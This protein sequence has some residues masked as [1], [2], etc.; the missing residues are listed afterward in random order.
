ML[1]Q[2]AANYRGYLLEDRK[3]AGE[4]RYCMRVEANWRQVE[5]LQKQVFQVKKLVG[6]W[7]APELELI[8]SNFPMYVQ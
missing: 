8:A 3:G 6:R 2:L 5:S 7:G 4:E 1:H